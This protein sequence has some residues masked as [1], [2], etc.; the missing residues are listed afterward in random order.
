M[1]RSKSDAAAAP[2]ALFRRRMPSRAV[3]PRFRIYTD[4]QKKQKK[5]TLPKRLASIRH[6]LASAGGMGGSSTRA[7]FLGCTCKKM[8]ANT[9]M[10]RGCRETF[11]VSNRA[12]PYPARVQLPLRL[13]H[14]IETQKG[15]SVMKQRGH[16]C[17][18]E[19]ASPTP[20]HTLLTT[21]IGRVTGAQKQ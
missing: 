7:T 11:M 18:D 21:A 2:P 20:R 16:L 13:C 14:K 8:S 5:W 1:T 15:V 17:R 9:W 4:H 3:S 10:R 6:F 12:A 19:R